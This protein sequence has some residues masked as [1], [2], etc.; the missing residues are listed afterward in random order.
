MSQE[1]RDEYAAMYA[2]SPDPPMATDRQQAFIDLLILQK[3]L[4]EVDFTK[5][6]FANRKLL[7]IK[8]AKKII[9]KGVK[10][11]KAIRAKKAWD[12]SHFQ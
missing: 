7:D 6:E 9:R 4:F 2:W 3:C 12:D 11:Q 8:R 1:D 5:K 10:R